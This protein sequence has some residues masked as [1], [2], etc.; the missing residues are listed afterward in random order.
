MWSSSRSKRLCNVYKDFSYKTEDR[1]DTFSYIE[2]KVV[3]VSVSSISTN[4]IRSTSSCH[5]CQKDCKK[6]RSVNLSSITLRWVSSHSEIRDD[7]TTIVR[8]R[9]QRTTNHRSKR[10]VLKLLCLQNICWIRDGC[11]ALLLL[12][13]IPKNRLKLLLI[14]WNQLVTTYWVNMCITYAQ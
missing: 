12:D 13:F 10:N 4:K 9:C 6:S 3:V 7:E 5:L 8:K 2:Q 14:Y 11:W 1:I